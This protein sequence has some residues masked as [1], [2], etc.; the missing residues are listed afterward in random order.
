MLEVPAQ[1]PQCLHWETEVRCPSPDHR[2]T[3]SLKGFRRKAT[4][5]DPLLLLCH[6]ISPFPSRLP[7]LF[8]EPSIS[9]VSSVPLYAILLLPLCH[10]WCSEASHQRINV[11]ISAFGLSLV[12]FFGIEKNI[13]VHAC[14]GHLPLSFLL[15]SPEGPCPS[16]PTSFSQ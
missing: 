14:C 16:H 13:V 6:Q 2:K 4:V 12:T 9:P 7:I 1:N 8:A 15:L 5:L 3:D 11:C 10:S